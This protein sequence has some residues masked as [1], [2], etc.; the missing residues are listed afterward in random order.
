MNL[1]E[2]ESRIRELFESDMELL[3][4]KNADYTGDRDALSNLRHFGFYGVVVRLTD[5][6]H[7][8]Q[9]FA[10]KGVFKIKEENVRDTLRD[11]RNYCHLGEVLLDEE[12]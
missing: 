11:I 9:T 6:F 7:R 4:D 8:L 5:K 3:R 12:E 2:L 1:K 10:D